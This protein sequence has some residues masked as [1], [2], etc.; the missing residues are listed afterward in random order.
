MLEHYT[1]KS[2]IQKVF[3]FNILCVRN[4]SEGYKTSLICGQKV[5]KKSNFRFICHRW[6]GGDVFSNW[7]ASERLL[8]SW[9]SRE[10]ERQ[11]KFAR[12]AEWWKQNGKK[13]SFQFLKIGKMIANAVNL[14]RIGGYFTRWQ[15]LVWPTKT[16][17]KCVKTG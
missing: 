14:I 5:S 7:T 10:K 2:N 9:V 6:G 12:Q 15:V 16:K 13:I 4:N 1:L 17:L 11:Y 3:L 8:A